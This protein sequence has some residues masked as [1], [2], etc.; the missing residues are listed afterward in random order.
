M[1]VIMADIAIYQIASLIWI[2]FS[3]SL[4]QYLTLL[5]S[6]RYK[7]YRVLAIL[8]AIGFIGFCINK[9]NPPECTDVA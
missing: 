7:L 4:F 1:P 5:H 6:E 3:V 2:K 8:S 9:P